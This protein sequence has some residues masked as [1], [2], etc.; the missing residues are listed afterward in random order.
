MLSHEADQETSLVTR[1][2]CLKGLWFHDVQGCQAPPTSLQRLAQL[3]SRTAL[4]GAND[5]L[6]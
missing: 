3:S 2:A 1:F 4:L 5:Q 6:T